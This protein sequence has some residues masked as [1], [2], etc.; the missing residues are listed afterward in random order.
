M[1]VQVQVFSVW[2]LPSE[3][4][5]EQNVWFESDRKF[6]RQSKS[7]SN[8]MDKYVSLKLKWMTGMGGER[9]S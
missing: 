2:Y 4:E 5:S 8:P 1:C 7:L 6:K 9:E 3:W